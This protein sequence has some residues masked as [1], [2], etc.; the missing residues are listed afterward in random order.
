MACDGVYWFIEE[1]DL[2]DA[3][4]FLTLDVRET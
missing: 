3:V 1:S 4:L 2:F